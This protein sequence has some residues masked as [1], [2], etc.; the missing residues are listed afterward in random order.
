MRAPDLRWFLKKSARK[1]V[2][3]ASEVGGV[4]ATRAPG[5]TVRVLTYHRFGAAEHDPFCVAVADFERHV[6]TLARLGIAV[7]LTEVERFLAGTGTLADGSVL[8]TIDDGCPSVRT[9]AAPILRR[10]DVPAVLFVPAGEMLDERRGTTRAP[11]RGA[12]STESA[13]DRM[14]WA[15]LEELARAG[16]TIGS[17]AW[18]HASLGRMP[19]DAAGEQALRS[20]EEIARRLGQ[21][22]TAFAYP[23]GTRA[24]YSDAIADVVR[25]AGYTCAFTSQ[26]GGI[27]SDSDPFALPRVKIEGG[28]ALWMFEASIRGGLDA[29]RWVDRTLWRMQASGG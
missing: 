1:T 18:T 9:H 12:A 28:E 15:E 21:P 27:R 6:A 13:D 7:S 24:D 3:V 11:M 22:V 10:Y 20:R 26:H 5:P 17:H 25:R 8:V 4:L 23:F 2:A 19:L 29:W 14:S 16:V